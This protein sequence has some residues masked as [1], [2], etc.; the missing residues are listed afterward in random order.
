MAPDTAQWLLSSPPAAYVRLWGFLV[1]RLVPALGPS[2]F[3][4]QG[5]SERVAGRTRQARWDTAPHPHGFR[6]FTVRGAEAERVEP[7]EGGGWLGERCVRRDGVWDISPGS[8]RPSGLAPSITKT[9]QMRPGVGVSCRPVTAQTHGSGHCKL[10]PSRTQGAK[11]IPPP[12]SSHRT[13]E[14][15]YGLGPPRGALRAESATRS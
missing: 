11:R 6:P 5:Q 3:R 13:A 8:E 12:S 10:L 7:P 1:T 14:Q 15:G 4:V 9:G 2:S